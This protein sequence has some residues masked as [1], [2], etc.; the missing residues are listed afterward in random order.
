VC[1]GDNDVLASIAQTSQLGHVLQTSEDVFLFLE[2]QLTAKRSGFQRQK[3]NLASIE[4]YSV[5]HQ[6]KKL[7]TLLNTL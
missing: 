4:Q 6:V 3:V 5:V 1:P 7:S 2:Q